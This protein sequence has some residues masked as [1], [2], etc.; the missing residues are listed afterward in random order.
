MSPFLSKIAWFSILITRYY[1]QRVERTNFF[2]EQKRKKGPTR[3]DLHGRVKLS[4]KNS[5]TTKPRLSLGLVTDMHS[6]HLKTSSNQIKSTTSKHQKSIGIKSPLLKSWA[7]PE[8][9]RYIT[10]YNVD[11]KWSFFMHA[12]VDSFY[13]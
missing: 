8:W 12:N 4:L 13:F 5:L 7:T 2:P 9:C 10:F 6:H 11:S 1:A 3:A